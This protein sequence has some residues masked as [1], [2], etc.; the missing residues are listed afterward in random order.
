VRRPCKRY[1][2]SEH[3]EIQKL[4]NGDELLYVAT[5][6]TNEVYL[7]NL[8]THQNQTLFCR[9]TI[10]AVTDAEPGA[11]GLAAVAAAAAGPAG[12]R[13]AAGAA[14]ATA[15]GA[16]AAFGTLPRRTFDPALFR[17][18]LLMIPGLKL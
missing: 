5:T 15:P 18:F 13:R 12:T 1:Q 6:T 10:A 3:L 8:A 9:A 14:D 17:L 2:R 7:I 4:A 11:S 16:R